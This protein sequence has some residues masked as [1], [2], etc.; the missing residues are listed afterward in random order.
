M[1]NY[2]NV[3]DAYL[4]GKANG[5]ILGVSEILDIFETDV[6]R[7]NQYLQAAV[8]RCLYA[9]NDMCDVTC[10]GRPYCQPEAKGWQDV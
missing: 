6:D 8:R 5:Y 9:V 10:A 2:E 3:E 4:K 1:I 7:L